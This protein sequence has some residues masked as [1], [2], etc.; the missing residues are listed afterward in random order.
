MIGRG[1]VVDNEE[2]RHEM[3]LGIRSRCPHPTHRGGSKRIGG[4]GRRYTIIL[5]DNE[6]G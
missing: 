5:K 4:R 2:F 3:K 6:E 1:D